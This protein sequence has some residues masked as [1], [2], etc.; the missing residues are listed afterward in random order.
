MSTDCAAI[1]VVHGLL[2]L[3]LV[4]SGVE[5]LRARY[6]AR[7]GAPTVT[8]ER[9]EQSMNALF[10][11]YGIATVA[12]ELAVTA[13]ECARG[14]KATLILFDYASLTYLFFF[15]VWFRNRVVFPVWQRMRKD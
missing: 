13:S 3:G 14:N 11:L 10:T 5:T 2:L 15:N 7:R 9:G 8:V 4:V 6:R 12:L 1:V